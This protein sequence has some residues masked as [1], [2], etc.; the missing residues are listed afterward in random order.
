MSAKQIHVILLITL[1]GFC[2]TPTTFAQSTVYFFMGKIANS[3]CIMKLNGKEAFELRGPLQKTISPAP[4]MQYPYNVYSPCT[5]KCT[6]KNEGKM[7]F[8][9]DMQFTNATSGVVS[10]MAGEI[11]LNLAEGSVYYVK[12]TNKGL[13]DVQ[14]KEITQK[15]ADKLLKNKK[16]VCLPEY[17]EE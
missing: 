2:S 15:E 4:P 11:Q 1:F 16:Y 6:F 12:V 7:L 8:S 9:V 3:T 17:I 5:K 10:K 14:F 13:H